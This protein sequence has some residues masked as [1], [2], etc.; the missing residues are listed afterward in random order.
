MRTNAATAALCVVAVACGQPSFRSQLQSEGGAA[1]VETD[2]VTSAAAAG[3]ARETL[4]QGGIGGV[5]LPSSG[6]GGAGGAAGQLGLDTAGV[7]A[8]GGR[9][10]TG[11][12]RGPTLYSGGAGGVAPPGR[13]GVGPL[14]ARSEGGRRR[15]AGAAGAEAGDAPSGCEAT[16][17]LCNGRDDDCDGRVD[18]EDPD[19]GLAFA[20]SAF[21]DL[22]T[23]LPPGGEVGVTY[24]EEVHGH[25]VLWRA[26]DS[27]EAGARL[28]WVE[29]DG[30]ARGEPLELS[31]VSSRGP[32]AVASS[33]A[34][35]AVVWSDGLGPRSVR[36]QVVDAVSGTL[37][38]DVVD[39]GGVLQY[40]TTH[41]SLV[42]DDGAWYVASTQQGTGE[43]ASIAITRVVAGEVVEAQLLDKA[44][45]AEPSMA[46]LGSTL[47][48]AWTRD[49]DA[50]GAYDEAWFSTGQ[51][52]EEL[53]DPERF[54]PLPMSGQ[55]Y[56]VVASGAAFTLAP[57]AAVGPL[58]KVGTDGQEL[59]RHRWVSP[60]YK[61]LLDLTSAATGVLAV[62][63]DVGPDE[64]S[65]ITAVLVAD[66]CRP[67]ETFALGTASAN[68][69][70]AASAGPNGALVVRTDEGRLG[71]ARSSAT[72]CAPEQGH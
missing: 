25:A 17:E 59:C 63:S 58:V 35:V 48:V 14:G 9:S 43:P 41:V 65:S 56:R 62:T 54:L 12:G 37:A 66:D 2:P 11:G 13:G 71:V 7:A 6:G 4:P 29:A 57:T 31:Q 23:Q 16:V 10:T 3:R 64:A 38:G 24:V 20:F 72:W 32:V 60:T 8:A 36:L 1:V 50:D 69:S 51:S 34:Q 46:I 21:E 47:G 26:A 5:V 53:V 52:L 67:G 18:R 55:A 33:R 45:G 49:S 15:G 68:A 61:E 22:V 70:S 27:S 40:G 44:A 42:G 28:Y 30:T 39:V 19:A